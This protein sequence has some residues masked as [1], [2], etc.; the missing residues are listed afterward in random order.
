MSYRVTVPCT[1]AQAEAIADSDSLF[2]AADDPPVLVADETRPDDWLIHAYFEHEPTSAEIALL[3]SLG[4]GA[5][6]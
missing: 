1:R 6:S 2:P 4:C 3:A 5:P